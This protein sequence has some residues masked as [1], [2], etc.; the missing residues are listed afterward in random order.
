MTEVFFDP[1]SIEMILLIVMI[2]F[3]GFL[4]SIAG[5]GGLISLPA[6]FA[7]GLPPHAAL[8]T[9]KFS[10]FFGTLTSVINYYRA[11][12]IDIKIGL[13]ATAGALTGSACGARVALFVTEDAINNVILILTPLVLALF[14]LK[15]RFYSEENKEESGVVKAQGIKAFLIGA[16]VGCYDGFYGPGTG[17][18][19]A[20]GFNFLLRADLLTASANARLAN[21]ASNAGAVIIF[22][23]NG[24]V[25]FPLAFYTAAAGIAGNMFGSRLALKKGRK[26]IKPLI[27]VVLMLLLFEVARQHMG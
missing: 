5:G 18:F 26:V 21:M 6:Y 15:E 14:L 9:N 4:D 8:A 13:I 3:A 22:L 11:N 17:A 27:V 25:L 1:G 24:K 7:F 16:F 19:M 12:K 20:I 2:F 23:I 10:G